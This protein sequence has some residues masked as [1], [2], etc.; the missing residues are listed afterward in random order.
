MKPDR[1]MARE[2]RRIDPLLE[3]RYV[4]TVGRWGIFHLLPM[5]ERVDLAIASRATELYNELWKRGYPVTKRVCEEQCALQ[6]K[7]RELVFYVTEEDGSYRPLDGRVL[8]KLRRMDH[9]RQ[10]WDLK[11]WREFMDAKAKLAK[12]VRERTWED[13]VEY[14]RK[15]PVFNAQAADILRGDSH[16]RAVNVSQPDKPARYPIAEVAKES[17]VDATA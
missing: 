13:H 2:L 4:E 5:N 10:N 9:M 12:D 14:V 7:D 11:D 1:H 15:D 17:K 6:V 16:T 3:A 8:E